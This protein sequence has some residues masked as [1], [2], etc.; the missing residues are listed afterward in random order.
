M[1]RVGRFLVL[2]TA[3]LSWVVGGYSDQPSAN[4]VAEGSVPTVHADK[5]TFDNAT[6]TYSAEGNVVIQDKDAT[7]RADRVQYNQDSQ[8][9]WADGHVRLNQA[10]QEWV[11]ANVAIGPGFLADGHVRLNQAAQEWVAPSLYY[12]FGTH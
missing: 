9:A 10:A 1:R 5:M 7:L 2:V 3:L 6:R 4:V 8:E 11:E 12:N